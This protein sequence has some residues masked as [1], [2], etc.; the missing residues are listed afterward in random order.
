MFSCVKRSPLDIR[1]GF[2]TGARQLSGSNYAREIRLNY[3]SVQNKNP[4]LASRD[5]V[6]LD[7]GARSSFIFYKERFNVDELKSKTVAQV[8]KTRMKKFRETRLT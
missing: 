8:L 7:S 3:G 1:N 2:N 4:F 6:S 5:T